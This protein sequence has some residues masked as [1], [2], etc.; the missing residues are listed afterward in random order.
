MIIITIRSSHIFFFWLTQNIFKF[1]RSSDGL[2]LLATRDGSIDT[3]AISL[4][5]GYLSMFLY[6]ITFALTGRSLN[7]YHDGELHTI[8]FTFITREVSLVIDGNE[9]LELQGNS[10]EYTWNTNND[11]DIKRIIIQYNKPTVTWKYTVLTTQNYIFTIEIITQEFYIHA[12][13]L[14]F[15]LL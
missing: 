5:N 4:I 11:E 3:L 13:R 8:Q 9:Q 7:T 12:L 14:V 6:S 15:D 2:L 1:Y 10:G